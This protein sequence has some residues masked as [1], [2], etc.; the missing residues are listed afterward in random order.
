MYKAD[1]ARRHAK[2]LTDGRRARY[3]HR[4]SEIRRG[5]CNSPMVGCGGRAAPIRRPASRRWEAWLARQHAWIACMRV[6]EATGTYGEALATWLDDAG[7]QVSVVNPMTIHAFAASRLSR[8]KT[9]RTDA[10]LIAQFCAT[11]Q[12]GALAAGP[13]GDPRAAGLGPPARGP[14]RDADPGNQSTQQRRGDARGRA[15]ARD[16][17][18]HPHRGNRGGPPTDP[19]SFHA[20]SRPARATRSADLDPG[21]RRVDRGVLLAELFDKQYRSA[22]QAA[23]FAGVCRGSRRSGGTL[24]RRS[25]LSKIGPSRLRKALY[26]PALAGLRFNPSLQ[27]LRTRLRARGKVPM[28]IVGA[29]MRKLMHLAY[30]G[31]LKS[32]RPSIR[33]SVRA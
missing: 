17:D 2:E 9:D 30:D 12:P 27:A 8:T 18:R 7:H 16:G 3:R 15:I 33:R 31:V 1:R 5:V 6:L 32:Q 23:A 13:P 4:Q 24:R 25:R 21:D 28:V 10:A 22:R 20:A 26:F 29:A 14:A 19:R 11:H